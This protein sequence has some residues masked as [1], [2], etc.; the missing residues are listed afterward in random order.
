M[1]LASFAANRRLWELRRPIESV[2]TARV[3][4]VSLPTS[5]VAAA[6]A[7]A[8]VVAAVEITISKEVSPIAVVAVVVSAFVVIVDLV[9][10]PAPF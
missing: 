2:S 9:A 3:D 1:T 5:V 4:S 6:F 10:F 8:V 7:A